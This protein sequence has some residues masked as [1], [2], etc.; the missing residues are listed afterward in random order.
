ML[1]KTLL[2]A[3]TALALVNLVVAAGLSLLLYG[4]CGVWGIP[5]ANSI[6]NMVVVPLM[7]LVLARRVGRLDNRGVL[8]STAV[9]LVASAIVGA[10]AYGIW[11]VLHA[12]LGGLLIAQLVEVPGSAYYSALDGDAALRARE[13]GEAQAWFR[14]ATAEIFG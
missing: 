10:A 6:A 1:K 3:A 13:A 4:P 12:A 7:W 8:V 2:G 9:A 14:T 11:T 5:L